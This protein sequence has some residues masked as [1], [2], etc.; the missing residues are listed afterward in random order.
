MPRSQDPLSLEFILLGLINNE[1]IHGYDLYKKITDLEGISLIWHIKQ[2][3]LY[4]LLEKLEG[5]ELV[6]SKILPGKTHLTR[7][8][9]QITPNGRAAFLSWVNQPVKHGR[10]MRQEFLAKLYFAQVCDVGA[11]KELIDKQKVMCGKWV[12]NYS[13]IVQTIN[14]EQQYEKLIYQYRISQTKA[15]ISWLDYCLDEICGNGILPTINNDTQESG[16]EERN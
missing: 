1:P 16:L 5:A 3:K 11:A 14:P 9:Y 4:A 6:S 15:M 8:E 7:K 13:T 10:D 12:S 2:G